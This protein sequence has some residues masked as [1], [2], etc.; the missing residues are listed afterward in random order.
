MQSAR[1]WASVDFLKFSTKFYSY[2]D[3]FLY[4]C[5]VYWLSLIYIDRSFEPEI[6]QNNFKF[7]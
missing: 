6:M 3:P 4:L 2:R 1:A 7:F 5:G